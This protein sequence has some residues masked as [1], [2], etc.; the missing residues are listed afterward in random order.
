[1][2]DIELVVRVRAADRAAFG[3]LVD[4]HHRALYRTALTIVPS[5]ADAEDVTQNAWLRAFRGI[6]Q[7]Q[8]ESAVTTWLIAIVRHAAIDCR[9]STRPRRMPETAEV[10]PGA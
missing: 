6:H 1:M 7:F 9:R 3:E 5:T 2:T 8:G 4:R 10:G